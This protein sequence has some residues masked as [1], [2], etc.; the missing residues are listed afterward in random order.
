MNI[1]FVEVNRSERVN[2]SI[3]GITIVENSREKEYANFYSNTPVIRGLYFIFSNVIFLFYVSDAVIIS[4]F[5]IIQ[6]ANRN[7]EIAKVFFFRY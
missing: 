5:K 4:F 6:R 3:L 1:F 2:N 7:R